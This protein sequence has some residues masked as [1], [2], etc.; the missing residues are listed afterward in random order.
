M[1]IGE[2]GTTPPRSDTGRQN[3]PSGLRQYTPLP[4][5]ARYHLHPNTSRRQINRI[6]ID[7]EIEES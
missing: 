4:G 3:L 7:L 6:K 5:T 1:P 2:H